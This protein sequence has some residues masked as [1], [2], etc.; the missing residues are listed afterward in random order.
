MNRMAIIALFV[1]FVFLSTFGCGDDDD[2]DSG[3]PGDDDDTTDDDDD[4]DDSSDDDDDVTPMEFY[5]MLPGPGQPGYNAD[6]EA[7][8][9]MYDRS[10]HVFIAA[11]TGLNM[12]VSVPE[13][14]N[15]E[16]RELIEDFIRET[17]GWDFETYAGKTVFDVVETYHKVAGLYAGS[18]IAADAYRYGVL[19]DQ[20]YPAEEIDLAREHLLLGME[21]LHISTA[22]TGVPGV[23]ARG[24]HR[25]DIPGYGATTETT[26]LFDISGNPLPVEKDNG[27]WREDNSP[28]GLYPEWIWEDSCSRDMILGWAAA[29]GACWEVIKDDPTFPKDVKDRMQEDARQIGM[30]LATVQESGFDL[31]I[32]DADGRTTFHGYLNENSYD[33]LYLPFLP[34]KDGVVSVMALGIVGALAYT[35]E[36]PELNE[37][38]YKELIAQRGLHRIVRNQMVGLDL[39][40]QSNYSSYN[41]VFQGAFL[42]TRYINYPK[43]SEA[44]SFSLQNHI[45]DHPDFHYRQ[46]VLLKQTLFDF[47]F[48][49]GTSFSNA[50]S[51]A[52]LPFNQK[53]IN[54]GVETLLDFPEPPYWGWAVENCDADEI[55]SG[56]CILNDGTEV[57]VLGYIGRNGALIID[58]PI[59]KAIRPNSNYH[60]RSDPFKP[61]SDGGGGSS[62]LPGVDFRWAYWIGR[63]VK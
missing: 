44:I 18:G 37:Y 42:A 12:D 50:W 56:I 6:L 54:R 51:P 13:E 46:P 32:M 24:L 22:I 14:D 11:G 21:G 41:M 1:L 40:V 39:W 8:A 47:V 59:P 29:F 25:R 60:W 34:I 28:G 26:P 49:A 27:T 53:A 35:A 63:W 55:A 62:Y 36:D 3:D 4:D 48:A 7:L 17:D 16:N 45:Y 10:F 58:T 57:R 61:N 5:A 38:L 33:R 31:E 19:R 52:W 9:R 30:S 43:V 2:D 15:Q 23:I 20:N